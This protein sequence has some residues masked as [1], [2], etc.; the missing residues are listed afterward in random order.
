MS[1]AESR[2]PETRPRYDKLDDDVLAREQRILEFWEN[3]EIFEKSVVMNQ[4]RDRYVFYEGPPTANGKPHFGHLMP[5]VYKDLFPRYKAMR[6]F[7]VER[8]GGWDTHGLPVEI[9]VEKELKLN[10]KAEIEAYGV[11]RF[12]EACRQSVWRY[13]GEWERMIQRMGFW[14]DLENAYITY[15]DDYIESVWWALHHIWEQGLLYKGHRVLHYCPRCGTPLSS[16]EVAQGYKEITEPSVT[17]KF[18]LRDRE[19]EY[20]L[21]WTTTPWTLPGNVAL[22]VGPEIDYAKVR[23][24]DEVYYLAEELH[25]PVLTEDHE[26]LEVFKGA[27]MD[28]WAYEPLLPF[29]KDAL[30]EEAERTR[31][32]T[33]VA[34]EGMVTTEEG[35]GVVHTAVM[36]G[37]EDYQ[38]G[39]QIGLPKRHT[40]DED[41]RFTDDVTPWA[42]RFVKEVEAD[43]TAQLNA[44]GKLYKAEDYTHSYPFCWRCRTPL[45]YYAHDSYFIRTTARQMDIIANNRQVHWHPEH[46]RDGRFGNFLDTMK[47]WALSRDR[48]WGTPLNIWNCEACGHELAVGS[49]EALVNRAV[50]QQLAA[51]VEFHR[52]Y[53]DQ[54]RLRCPECEGEMDRVPHVIDAWFDS[55]MMHTAQWHYPFENE[56]IFQDQFPAD[57]ICEALD[58][59]RGWFYS[60]LVTST[61]LYP[62][63]QFPYPHP[64]RHVVVTGMGLDVQRVKMSKSLGNVLDPW[65]LIDDGGADALRWYFYSDS[66][67][68]RDKPLS[69]EVV[70]GAPYQFLDTIRNTYNFFALYAE[71]DGFDPNQYQLLLERRSLLDRWILSRLGTTARAVTDALDGYDVVSATR[72]LEQ[73]VD[74]LSNWYVRSSRRRFWGGDLDTDKQ[75]AYLTLHYVLIELTKLLAPFVPFL[76]E[77]IYQ[78]LASG[79]GTEEVEAESVHMC[80]YPDAGERLIDEALERQME[81]VRQ[82]VALGRAARN[83]A[84]IKVRQP[85]RQMVI[86]RVAGTELLDEGLEQL[87]LQELNL[88]ELVYV[89]DLGSYYQPQVRPNQGEIGPKYGALTRVIVQALEAV[90]P[91]TVVDALEATGRF[92][93]TVD[94]QQVVLSTSAFDV[95]YVPQPGVVI[96]T[97][98][99]NAVALTTEID[100]VLREEGGV[101]ELIHRIQLMRKAA[102][103]E[104]TDRIL[105]YIRADD[106]LQE[107]IERKAAYIEEETLAKALHPG[108]I[109]DEVDYTEIQEIN[110]TTVEIGLKRVS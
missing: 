50:D 46:M 58:Q 16:H 35:T 30:G 105:L 96:L 40:V 4:G 67:P 92:E 25:E 108:E 71:I 91:Q 1:A 39:E 73:F 83:Q 97:E 7:Y 8:K 65:E 33:V 109:P 12:I 66:A 29:L 53:I 62:S 57:F 42:G 86:K 31:A 93:V 100:G 103:Y 34:T 64:Y 61:L 68:W 77:A 48:Y 104:V 36:Y 106:G 45:L 44:E 69:K 78:N 20:V 80:R 49:R 59:T 32:W 10:S 95:E 2:R 27:E 81:T 43:I 17:V 75:S 84:G 107:T 47:D 52:P 60:L 101:R 99:Q 3:G 87:I 98:D 70:G 94:D 37:E 41:G 74:N 26:V 54:V 22:A 63:E 18:K 102:G 72:S 79:A 5:R 14:I 89:D 9:E 24:G 23:Q 6:G 85:L 76:S 90:D 88:K 11:E 21:A 55:G 15:T 28:G 13:K 38:L 19:D 56:S 82:L 51:E 110:G